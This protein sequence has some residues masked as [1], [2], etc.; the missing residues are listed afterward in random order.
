M[1]EDRIIPQTAY[2]TENRGT[3]CRGDDQ[4]RCA[5]HNEVFIC[6]DQECDGVDD[7]P[8]GSDEINCPDNNLGTLTYEF[9]HFK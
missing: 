4:V 6:K 2:E 5:N 3:S 9:L 1:T 8:D 7:C